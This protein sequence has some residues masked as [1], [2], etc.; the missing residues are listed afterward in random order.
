MELT[1]PIRDVEKLAAMKQYLRARSLR[2]YTLLTLALN[3]GLRISDILCI[4]IGDVVDY[5]GRGTWTVKQAYELRE[6]KTRKY[7]RFP[8]NATAREALTEYLTEQGVT[9]AKLSVY[10]FKSR[11][12]YNRPIS[13]QMAHNVISKAAKAADIRERIGCHGLR[14]TFGYHAH[15]SGVDVTVLQTIFNHSH[16]SVTLSYIGITQQ[17][18][19]DVY[20]A[21]AL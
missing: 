11:Q 20:N 6:G 14:K 10:L 19:D 16:P 8:L 17:D 21:L 9:K 1:Q 18:V 12:G 15:K 4:R 3:S 5:Q 13:R 2:D 7:K